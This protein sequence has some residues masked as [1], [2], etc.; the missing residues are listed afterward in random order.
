ME[1]KLVRVRE[2]R[3][4]KS[5]VFCSY[6]G[7]ADFAKHFLSGSASAQ[8]VFLLFGNTEAHVMERLQET[9][10]IQADGRPRW[11]VDLRV[12]RDSANMF[13]VN[14]VKLNRWQ[15]MVSAGT[16]NPSEFVGAK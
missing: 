10:L 11:M 12:R 2:I 9:S 1:Q 7:E 13:G 14:E 8:G 16:L 5:E 4:R 15:R 3:K 6:L